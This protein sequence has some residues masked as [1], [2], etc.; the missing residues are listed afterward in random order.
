L[1]VPGLFRIF[2]RHPL[3]QSNLRTSSPRQKPKPP[4]HRTYDQLLS[5]V[6]PN[7][8]SPLERRISY[9]Q[10]REPSKS[11]HQHLADVVPPRNT[12]SAFPRTHGSI[13][14]ALLVRLVH[15]NISS[16][17]KT[18]DFSVRLF[19]RLGSIS[20]NPTGGLEAFV[21]VLD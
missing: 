8:K 17:R 12:T 15:K 11:Q 20:T 16:D 4:A 7:R 2:R 18:F 3:S 14:R 6:Y 10:S 19:M 5:T 1:L 9:V 13:T 21:P